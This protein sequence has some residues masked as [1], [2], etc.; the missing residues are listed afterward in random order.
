MT[1]TPHAL[2]ATD[3]NAIFGGDQTAAP[4]VV[5]MPDSK[6]TPVATSTV[7]PSTVV[8]STVVPSAKGVGPNPP[9]INAAAGKIDAGPGIVD[10]SPAP[11]AQ[12]KHAAPKRK[13]ASPP[14]IDQPL[15]YRNDTHVPDGDPAVNQQITRRLRAYRSQAW[16][17]DISRNA[18]DTAPFENLPPINTRDDAEF[19][20][21]PNMLPEELLDG[22][23]F[24]DLVARDSLPIPCPADREGYSPGRDG[25]YWMQGMADFLK[26]MQVADELDVDVRSYLDF[27]CATGRVIRHFCAQ[28]DVPKI[29][30]SDL[31]AR[32]VRWMA[33]HLPM[34][35]RPIANHAVPTLPIADGSINVI[36]A[37]SV[38]TH[39]DAFEVCW[40]A[41]LSRIL[42]RGGFAYL[43]VHNE[44]TWNVLKN[45]RDNPENRLIKSMLEIHPETCQQLEG[46]M[47]NTRT[48]Y[49]F[50]S[51]G[52]YRAQVFHSNHYLRQVW[53]R[54][55]KV[56]AILDCHHVRQSVVVLRKK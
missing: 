22:R 40:L 4:V 8:P 28:T 10:E 29:W 55:F 16:E 13:F 50:T 34:N 47:P 19:T 41:E 2:S 20:N 30:G 53:G 21:R 26:V 5:E 11:A 49:R 46:P 25:N 24:K 56:H 31:N 33:E 15:V 45:E 18:L 51:F 36:S 27:G 1:T 17:D 37:F 42:S 35:V 54:F 52:P 14:V 43:T 7:V 23:S 38:F 12:V 39:I 48:V 32:H 9:H 3:A 6:T 44:A